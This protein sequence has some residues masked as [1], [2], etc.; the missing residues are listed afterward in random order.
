MLPLV[1]QAHA[2][3][4]PPC[5]DVALSPVTDTGVKLS[6]VV[7]FPSWPRLFDPQHLTPPPK[8]TAH[9]KAAPVPT[10]MSGTAFV[11]PL[12]TTGVV[13][14]MVVPSPSCPLVFMP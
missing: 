9:A 12:I 5:T 11:S 10:S 3:T 13:R 8:T 7:P 2:W 14:W 4:Q 6:V 1:A